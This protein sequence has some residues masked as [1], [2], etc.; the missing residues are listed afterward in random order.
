[1]L[2]Y[3]LAAQAQTGW[4]YLAIDVLGGA[5]VVGVI[6]PPLAL[7]RCHATARPAD[8]R[9]WREGEEATIEI[10]VEN[11]S[12]LP[13]YWIALTDCSG[14]GTGEKGAGER[15][16]IPYVPPRGAAAIRWTVTPPR[17]GLYRLETFQAT[18]GAPFGLVQAG[19]LLRISPLDLIVLP[20]WWALR[21]RGRTAQDGEGA[22][23][24][25]TIGAETHGIRSYRSGDPLRLVHWRSTARQGG[26]MVREMEQPGRPIVLLILDA[27]APLASQVGR[28]GGRGQ[29]VARDADAD[30]LFDTGVRLIA[31]AARWAFDNDYAVVLRSNTQTPPAPPLGSADGLTWTRLLSYLAR[32]ERLPVADAVAM[33][34]ATTGDAPAWIAL[35]VSTR[36]DKA[37]VEMAA[38]LARRGAATTLAIGGAAIDPQRIGALSDEALR[39]LGERQTLL[40]ALT[41]GGVRV[42]PFSPAD[43]TVET[44]LC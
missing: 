3:V 35:I 32:A 11:R 13:C 4:L 44:P 42:T 24:R 27:R 22:R 1:M 20:R 23:P 26:L 9:S 40:D 31:S 6:Y 18:C 30:V 5:F 25:R 21:G 36:L 19:R 34:P 8:R 2:A 33:P 29:S 39:A 28:R 15:L 38:M 7:R 10:I 17:R 41:H 14:V 16:F 12:F 37:T 43:K